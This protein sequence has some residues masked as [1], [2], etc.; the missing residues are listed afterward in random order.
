[1]RSIE[2]RL[3]TLEKGLRVGRVPKAE[4]YQF[5]ANIYEDKWIEKKKAEL[6][7]K[8]GTTDGVEFIEFTLTL[9]SP[10]ESQQWEGLSLETDE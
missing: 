6:L 2:G 7:A 1:M 5:Y 8:Y 10:D 4:R 9:E 3:R